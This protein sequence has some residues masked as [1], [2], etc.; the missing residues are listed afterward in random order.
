MLSLLLNLNLTLL[1]HHDLRC[2]AILFNLA[3]R[4]NLLALQLDLRLAELGP[5][6]ART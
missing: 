5:I 3:G 1:L 2:A 6:R 4:A